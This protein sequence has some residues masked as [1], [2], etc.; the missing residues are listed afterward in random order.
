[1]KVKHACVTSTRM[2]GWIALRL[3]AMWILVSTCVTLMQS[4]KG[5]Y[6][7]IIRTTAKILSFTFCYL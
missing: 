2:R 6:I 4:T 1:M 7:K 3:G 5:N